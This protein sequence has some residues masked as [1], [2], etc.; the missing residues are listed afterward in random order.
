MITDDYGYIGRSPEEISYLIR[1]NPELD[2]TGI[3]CTNP[4]QYNSS[5]KKLYLDLPNLEDWTKLDRSLTPEEFHQK[6]KNE[7]LMP[8]EYKNMDIEKWLINQCNNNKELERIQK[9]LLIYKEFELINLLRYLK[10]IVDTFR[11]NKI[12]LGVGRGSSTASYVLFKIGIHRIDSLKYN[13]NVHE[14]LR[15]EK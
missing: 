4:E 13:L 10:Y 15:R 3:I 5:M 11:K 9:E 14:F 6:L 7:W 12:V 8:N 2:I 1:S